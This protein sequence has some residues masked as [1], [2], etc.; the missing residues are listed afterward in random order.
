MAHNYLRLSP[1]ENHTRSSPLRQRTCS[2]N[3]LPEPH[4]GST[5]TSGRVR[6]AGILKG[7]KLLDQRTSLSRV[8]SLCL[9]GECCRRDRLSRP[10]PHRVLW[11]GFGLQLELGRSGGRRGKT[12]KAPLN[13]PLQRLTPWYLSAP[14]YFELLHLPVPHPS[15]WTS[16]SITLQDVSALDGPPA[17]AWSHT[18]F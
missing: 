15:T 13:V 8:V 2:L 3:G 7:K 9:A 17:S 12:S 6:V 4:E 14:W 1:M 5:L 10:S 11:G 16:D 18:I